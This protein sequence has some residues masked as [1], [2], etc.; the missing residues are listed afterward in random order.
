MPKT[1]NSL[2]VANAAA[3]S[4]ILAS[5]HA[6]AFE[7]IN[8]YRVP[9]LCVLRKTGT[10]AMTNAA[11]T[12]I[13]FG[14]GEEVNDTDDMHSITSNTARI[15]PTTA[16]LY[17]F[18]GFV[19][20]SA[21]PTSGMALRITKNG[22]TTLF[23]VE[24]NASTIGQGGTCIESMNGTTDYVELQAY[25]SHGSALTTN[26]SVFPSFSAAWLGQVS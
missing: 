26:G 8:N 15:T 4:A 6:K 25:Y 3:G 19:Y 7:N 13:T 16:G 10:Q 22:A 21:F 1:Y 5:D 14:S 17:L 23:Y 18:T 20:L 9:P 12:S 24:N 11:F 2:T